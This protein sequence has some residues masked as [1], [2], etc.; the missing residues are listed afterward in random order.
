MRF[1]DNSLI[2]DLNDNFSAKT[3]GSLTNYPLSTTNENETSYDLL[4]VIINRPPIIIA[5]ITEA[6]TPSIQQYATADASGKYMYLF[7][8]GSVKVN[9]GVDITLTLVAQ[10]PDVLNVENGIPKIIPPTTGLTYLWRKDGIIITSYSVS[11]LQSDLTI[12]DNVITFKNT[13]P[14]YAGVYTC[15]VSND[16]GTVTSEPITL[17]VLNLDFDSYFYKN[18]IRNPYGADGSDEWNSLSTDLITKNVSK[19]PSQEFIKPN[20]V[21]LFGYTVDMMHPRPY[22]IDTGVIK[23]L[24]MTSN[25]LGKDASYFTR[26]RYKLVKDGGNF[27]VR[28]YQDIDVT[29]IQWLIKGGVYGVEGVRAFFSCYLGNGVSNFIPVTDFTD[30]ATRGNATNYVMNKPRI[31]TEN[32]LNSGPSTGNRETVYVTVEEYDNETRLSSKILNPD[33]TTYNQSDKI[34]ILDPWSKRLSNYWSQQYYKNDIYG[35]GELSKG[36]AVDATL[37]TAQELYPT[38][39][40]R[41]TYGQYA[42]FNKVVLERLNPNTTKVRITLNFETN[43]SRLFDYYFPIR[44]GG[45]DEPYEAESYSQPYE[46]HSWHRLQ[47]NS[48]GTTILNSQVNLTKNKGKLYNEFLPPINEPRGMITALNLSLIPIL[49][50]KP[51]ETKYYTDITLNVN[52]TKP[53]R[54]ETGLIS[55]VRP[56]DPKN[57]LGREIRAQFKMLSDNAINVNNQYQFDIKDQIELSFNLYNPTGVVKYSDLAVDTNSVFPFVKNKTI[58]VE[59]TP[60]M[61]TSE[62]INAGQKFDFCNYVGYVYR[63]DLSAYSSEKTGD[64]SL[65]IPNYSESIRRVFEDHETTINTTQTEL[66]YPDNVIRYPSTD[67]ASEWKGKSRY[68]VYLL[69]D[70]SAITP[71]RIVNAPFKQVTQLSPTSLQ[72]YYLTM[73]FENPNNKR[74]TLSRDNTIFPGEGSGSINL[75]YEID[76]NGVLICKLPKTMLIDTPVNQGGLKYPTYTGSVS[77]TGQP[78]KGIKTLYTNLGTGSLVPLTRNIAYRDQLTSIIKPISE[79]INYQKNNL[80]TTPS[81][82]TPFSTQLLIDFSSSLNAYAFDQSKV[83][84]EVVYGDVDKYFAD[85]SNFSID[86]KNDFESY[87]L[88]DPQLNDRVIAAEAA[89]YRILKFGDDFIDQYGNNLGPIKTKQDRVQVGVD[90]FGRPEYQNSTVRYIIIPKQTN[91]PA[92]LSKLRNPNSQLSLIAVKATQYELSDDRTGTPLYGSDANGLFYEVSYPPIQ[93]SYNGTYKPFTTTNP[94]DALGPNTGVT[95]TQAGY[96][97]TGP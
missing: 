46:R 41:Y 93:D 39:S 92:H 14:E 29:D 69:V 17:E 58:L 20:R 3:S 82:K 53:S 85:K 76:G 94:Q 63:T 71:T 12:K 35:L 15:E 48:W 61:L 21:D 62:D 56:Y 7:P 91:K 30:I 31:S 16:I 83:V 49:T 70:G 28:A 24:D 79:S 5:S 27:L 42:E 36:D 4:P 34:T 78:T 54:V 88:R 13:Q 75:D 45:S 90:R 8:D 25:L 55:L 37:L 67:N 86:L 11:S 23:N 44:G 19:L 1:P 9:L 68:L 43:D 66:R 38:E 81:L 64:P 87:E 2:G 40:L 65:G 26:S 33:G 18:L 73:D 60:T 50:Q 57:I 77:Y 52:N 10:Q 95:V 74:V 89:G 72:S 97:T 59:T 80:N 6:S 51:Q 84:D 96:E 47:N 22:Q 32:F